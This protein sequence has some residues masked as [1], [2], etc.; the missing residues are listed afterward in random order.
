MSAYDVLECPLAFMCNHR[1]LGELC[2]GL[3]VLNCKHFKKFLDRL[4]KWMLLNIDTLETTHFVVKCEK[5]RIVIEV[6]SR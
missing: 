4:F 1:N 3:K 5:N 2:M 6:R